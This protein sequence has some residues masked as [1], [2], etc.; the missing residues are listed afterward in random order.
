MSRIA[1][2]L[3]T[4]AMAGLLAGAV[5]ARAANPSL[6]GD[7]KGALNAGAQVPRAS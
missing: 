1:H 3:A 4:A 7:W 2:V 5:P 6:D